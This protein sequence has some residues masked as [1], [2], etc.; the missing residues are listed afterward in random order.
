M[1]LSK[2]AIT[3]IGIGTAWVT[4]LPI[5]I[6]GSWLFVVGSMIVS[7]ATIAGNPATFGLAS[8]PFIILVL[9]QCPTLLIQLALIV[10]YLNHIIHNIE[11]AEGVRIGLCLGIIFVPFVMP[12]YY[13]K[14]IWN[15][16]V[17]KKTRKEQNH[18]HISTPVSR[19]V[20]VLGVLIPITILLLPFVVFVIQIIYGI[21]FVSPSFATPISGQMTRATS[22]Q[23][24]FSIS[25]PANWIYLENPGGNRGDKTYVATISSPGVFRLGVFG[26]I[27]RRVDQFDTLSAV[28]KW[29]EDIANRNQTQSA[30]PSTDTSVNRTISSNEYL[31]RGEKTILREYIWGQ[32]GS[33]GL[34]TIVR[35]CLDNYR[36]HNGVG[37]VL[38]LCTDDD[39]YSRVAP[40]FIQMIESFAY[41]D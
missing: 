13:Y 21:F 16:S 33:L 7:S 27:R 15:Q 1:R 41:L 24:R 10:I 40:A 3:W 14:F 34:T 31:I 36:I 30:V 18:T 26:V 20:L 37:F 2:S 28:A 5:L 39:E 8:S 22:Q 11:L 32:G 23:S 4:I 38:T 9:L 25:Y 29:G 6:I 17:K 19:R 35:H 12:I